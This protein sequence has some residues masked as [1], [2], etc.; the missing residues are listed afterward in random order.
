MNLVH[1]LPK[2]LNASLTA[3]QLEFVD[4]YL[5]HTPFKY[6]TPEEISTAWEQ[7]EE[8]QAKGLARSIGVSNFRPQD[9]EPIFKTCKSIPAVN[10][11]EFHPYL[12]HPELTKIMRRHNVGLVGYGPLV[13]LRKEDQLENGPIDE[14]V[15]TLAAKYNVT[16]DNILL[17]WQMDKGSGIVTTSSKESRLRSY[18]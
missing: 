10:Q 11:I 1:D 5:I 2:A 4:L 13:S 16:E 15:R 7:M 12:Q 9:L 14:Y 17:R 18:L 8:L 3:L 6:K